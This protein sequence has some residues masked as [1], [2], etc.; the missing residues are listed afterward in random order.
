MLPGILMVVFLPRLSRLVVEN[1]AKAS[2]E[3]LLMARTHMLVAFLIGT[4]FLVEAQ[5][6]ISIIYGKKYMESVSMLKVMSIAV[7]F[8][9]AI[10]GYTNCLISFGKDK[11]MVMVTVV[12]VIVSVGGGFILVPKYGA[13]GAA[14][15]IMLI[16][17]S[18]WIASLPYY[19][20]TI[21][22]LQ[23]KAWVI[24]LIAGT[25]TAILLLIMQTLGVPYWLRIPVGMLAY[26]PF[27]IYSA[28]EV[29]SS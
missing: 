12:S 10:I 13:F 18:G 14:I 16:D 1:K 2:H 24:P 28:K 20:N 11:V 8:N 7:I 26:S 27:I 15:V 9:Y 3:A 4:F 23:L 25:V 22:S 19:K 29:L 21:G 6:I 5:S 17:L